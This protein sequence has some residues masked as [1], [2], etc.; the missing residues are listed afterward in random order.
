MF[1]KEANEMI[2]LLKKIKEK[3]A[4]DLHLVA[5]STPRFRIDG[6]I[7]PDGYA[8]LS[9]EDTKKLA[10]SVMNPIQIKKFEKYFCVEFTYSV[11]GMGRFR[12]NVH[13]QRGTVAIAIRLIPSA[14]GTLADLNLPSCLHEIALQRKGLVLVT[15]PAGSGKSTTLAAMVRIINENRQVHIITIEDPIEY[16]HEHK[17][18]VIEQIEVGEDIPTFSRALKY[19]LRQDPDVI[20]VGEMRDLETISL[21]IT[22][23]ETGHLVFGTLHT[24]DAPQAINRIIDVFPTSQQNQVRS[25]LSLCLRNVISQQ[26][27]PKKG[28]GRIPACEIL[29][30]TSAVANLIR[31]EKVEQIYTI[32]ETGSAQGMRS[33]RQDLQR[34][35]EKGLISWKDAMT[36]AGRYTEELQ[37]WLEKRGYKIT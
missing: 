37:E 2:S 30:V 13:L 33:M 29:N 28:G 22:A 19:A 3:R 23:A 15:G 24:P 34:L 27:L 7:V 35:M 8:K 10:Y 32:I 4:S 25:Q 5:G 31:K 26:L 16:L 14:V 9:G 1:S 6:E 17:K 18:A 12:F 20:L 11:W 36:Y 21:A